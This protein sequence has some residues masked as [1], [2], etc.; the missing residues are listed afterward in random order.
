VKST[1][2]AW[3]IQTLSPIRSVSVPT[4]PATPAVRIRLLITIR[5]RSPHPSDQPSSGWTF[6]FSSKLELQLVKDVTA[7]QSMFTL[8]HV[9]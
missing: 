9:Q 6:R 1:D 2:G 3:I 5:L 7:E 8:V 4:Q